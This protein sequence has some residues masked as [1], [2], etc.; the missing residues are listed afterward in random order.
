MGIKYHTGMAG[1]PTKEPG[2]KM[3]VP[4]RIMLTAE[5]SQLIREV[6]KEQGIDV[7]AW[8]RPILLEAARDG[9]ERG[10]GRKSQQSQ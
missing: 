3:D 7:S 9:T 4:L 1:R 8:A 6:A 2:Q 10:K 5:Q